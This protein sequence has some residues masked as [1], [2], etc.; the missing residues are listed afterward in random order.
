MAVMKFAK[1]SR[2]NSS[3]KAKSKIVYLLASGARNLLG[4]LKK[5]DLSTIMQ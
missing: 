2:T 1:I 4:K 3:C 5:F